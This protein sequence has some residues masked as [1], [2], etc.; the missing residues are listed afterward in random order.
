MAGVAAS[1]PHGALLELDGDH[2]LFYEQP[3]L[4]NRAVLDFLNR[5]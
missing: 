5:T 4:W 2:S 1:L 3:D